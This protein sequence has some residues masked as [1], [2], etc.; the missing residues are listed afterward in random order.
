M[1]P[2][3][4][5][6]EK[7]QQAKKQLSDKFLLPSLKQGVIALQKTTLGEAAALAGRQVH[8]VGIGRKVVNG[9]KTDTWCIRVYVNQKV[10]PKFA[11]DIVPPFLNGVPTDVV[12][13]APAFLAS[14]ELAAPVNA[15]ALTDIVAV[16]PPNCTS[17]RQALQDP[18]IA[19]VSTGRNGGPQGTI[20][21]F[22]RSTDPGDNPDDDF[23]LSN[24]HIFGSTP[25]AQIFQPAPGDQ[26]FPS[27]HFADLH[28]SIPVVP[29]GVTANLIDA[30]IGRLRTGVTHNTSIC[31][32]GPLAGTTLASEDMPV[33]KHG[34]T[35]G[36]REGIVSDE[37][38]DGL[39]GLN[40]ADPSQVSLFVDQ[41]RIEG[42]GTTRFA[43][44]GDSGSLVVQRDSNAAVGLLFAASVSVNDNYALANPIAVV[45]SQLRISIL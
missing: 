16:N 2:A 7:L 28:R 36:L 30:A 38:Y 12:E 3:Q 19:G 40:P 39:I 43:V 41:I 14:P 11:A 42:L 33:L 26:G 20:A 13:S 37:S 21:C 32:L 6:L 15:Q 34:R 4:A 44:N 18:V 27:L 5:D 22:C 1:P 17:N 10:D 8:A 23:V 31:S 29:G 25:G 45:V 9:R 24:N 35:T